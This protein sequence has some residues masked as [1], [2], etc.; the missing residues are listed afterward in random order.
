MFPVLVGVSIIVFAMMRIAPGDVASMILL[1]SGDPGEGGSATPEEV[2][3]LRERLGLNQP[4]YRQYLDFIGGMIRMNPGV[5]LWT[6]QPVMSVLRDRIGVTIEIAVLSLIISLIIGLPTGIISALRQDRWMD[7]IFR[8]VSI[9]GLSIPNF[10]LATLIILIL[11]RYFAWAPP[12]GYTSFTEDPIRNIQ[13][14]FWPAVVLGYSNAAILSRMTRSVM[15]EVLREDYVRTARSKGL[16]NRVVTMRHAF[17]NA[18]L[19]VLTLATLQ[20][21]NL[22]G[23]TVI[24]E[25]VFTLP[26]VGRFLIDAINHRDYPVVQTIIV[27]TAVLFIV[28]NLLVDVLYAWLDPRI[29]Y[30]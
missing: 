19:P 4:Y 5:S 14:F 27:L 17:R 10:W 30:S 6:E 18:F 22:L 25:S 7:Y 29:R 16:K 24:I 21:G 23:G 2:A 28:M 26:G 12:L 3:A 11:T 9:S 15:L 20:L 1:G 13:Q 8:V